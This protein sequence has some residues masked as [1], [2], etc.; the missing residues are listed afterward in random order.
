ME[1]KPEVKAAIE[2]MLSVLPGLKAYQWAQICQ[3]INMAYSSKESRVVLDESDIEM[4]KR[5]I[6]STLSW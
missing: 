1:N 6:K 4:I 2:A 5:N 3:H